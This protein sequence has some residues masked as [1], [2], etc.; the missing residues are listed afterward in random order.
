MIF[1]TRFRRALAYKAE[2]IKA[3]I[4]RQSF[5]GKFFKDNGAR[6]NGKLVRTGHTSEACQHHA[7]SLGIADKND[8]PEL[9]K[10]I[11]ADF[12]DK[13]GNGFSDI[14]KANIIVGLLMRITV[15]LEYGENE[16]VIREIKKVYG[17]MAGI[18]RNIVL[19]L[20]KKRQKN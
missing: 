12:T 13:N 1:V 16:K 9:Y 4:R 8:Y 5:N 10:V 15:L 11:S 3:T 17:K 14:G 6:K 18:T 20:T 7:F 19:L 2:V